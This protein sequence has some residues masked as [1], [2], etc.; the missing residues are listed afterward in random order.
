MT[1]VLG[2]GPEADEVAKVSCGQGQLGRLAAD[3]IGRSQKM[4]DS[5]QLR[6][7]LLA[8]IKVVRQSSF[9]QDCAACPDITSTTAN[10]HL[11]STSERSYVG[12]DFVRKP[13]MIF[14]ASF[15]LFGIKH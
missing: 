13:Y 15:R 8:D 7:H 6:L 2:A 12:A 10:K 3:K 1:F 4:L 9:K 14:K 11:F 5:P